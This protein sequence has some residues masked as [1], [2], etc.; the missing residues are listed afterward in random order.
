MELRA[1]SGGFTLI[2]LMIVVVIATIL[3]SI[4]IPSYFSQLRQSRRTE[5]KTAL[6]DLAGRE[7]SY[8]STNGSVYTN[9]AGSLGYTGWPVKTPNGYYQITF[10]GVNGSCIAGQGAALGCDPNANAP[11]GPAYYLI[12][13]PV[14]GTSQAADTQCTLFAVDSLGNQFSQGTNTVAQCWSQ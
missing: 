5:A 4:A 1:R 14:A 9:A 8:F 13:T 10:G 7:E 12:A 6:L 2:E 3:L 11:N